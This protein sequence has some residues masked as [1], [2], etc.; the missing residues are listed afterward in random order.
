MAL[1]SH[2]EIW[3]LKLWYNKDK[4]RTEDY[5]SIEVMTKIINP[6]MPVLWE[7]V[8]DLIFLLIVLEIGK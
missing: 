7:I 6:D 5:K 8:K 3:A 1:A 4:N 2:L